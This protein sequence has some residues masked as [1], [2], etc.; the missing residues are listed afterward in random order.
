MLRLRP[1]IL[2]WPSFCMLCLNAPP[3]GAGGRGGGGHFGAHFAPHFSAPHVQPQ[4][5]APR[6]SVPMPRTLAAPA[7]RA[8][9]L[10]T[11]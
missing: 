9:A 6:M 8:P 4:V 5:S 11:F 10:A 7:H 3:A 2:I 1:L